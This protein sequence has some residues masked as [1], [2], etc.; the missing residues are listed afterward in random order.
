MNV[1]WRTGRTVGRTI[2]IQAADDPS[3]D[4]HLVGLMDTP[5]LAERVVQA[6]N[7]AARPIAVDPDDAATVERVA[8]VLFLTRYP[9]SEAFD[10]ARRDE[11]EMGGW[12]DRARRF[13]AALAD[14]GTEND[15][16]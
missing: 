2:Y 10:K 9:G 15:R 7:T 6:L 11:I 1:R 16:G 14:N 13:L 4:D 12:R 5:E 3:K 8:K